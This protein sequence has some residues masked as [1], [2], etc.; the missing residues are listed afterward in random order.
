MAWNYATSTAEWIKNGMQPVSETAYEERQAICRGCDRFRSE[1]SRCA[2]CGCY[3][4]IKAAR[5]TTPGESDCPLGKWPA[6]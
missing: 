1:D 4:D 3:I 5:L 6:V 2:E